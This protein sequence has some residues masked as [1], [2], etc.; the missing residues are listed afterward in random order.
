MLDSPWRRSK[1]KKVATVFP[2]PGSALLARRRTARNAFVSETSSFPD[3]PMR[4][5][6]SSARGAQ[7]N[8]TSSSRP[9]PPGRRHQGWR[10]VAFPAMAV[11]LVL[12]LLVSV[13]LILRVLDIGRPSDLND[14]LSGFSEVHNLFELDPDR[15]VYQT[16]V[17]RRIFFG[18]QE[19]PVEKSAETLRAFCLGGSTVRGRPYETDT[20]F[21]AWLQVE[22]AAREPTRA[23]EIVNCGGL[24]YASYRLVPLLQE[25]LQYSPDAII[26]ATGHNEFLEDRTYRDVKQRSAVRAWVEDRLYQSRLVSL[27]RGLVSTDEAVPKAAPDET[28]P[29]DGEVQARLDESTGYATYHRDDE[30]Q[31]QVVRQFED[32]LE[33]LI[34]LCRDADV[35]IIFVRLGS[36]LRD[37]PP[38]K[39]EHGDEVT[40]EQQ[41]EFQRLFDAGGA[42]DRENPL[43]AL[44]YYYQAEQ[45]D[46]R[47]P[48]LLFRIA[49]ALDRLG[50][51]EVAEA[52]YIR[53]RDEDV[54]PLR[55]VSELAEVV[56][57]V[58]GKHDV[59]LVNA[60]SLLAATTPQRI[61]G[62]DLY[63]DHV[64]PTIAGHQHIAQ[65]LA[66]VLG[67]LG[68]ARRTA[69]D[70]RTRRTAYRTHFETLSA[71]FFANGGRRVG[72][73][74]NWARRYRLL[75]EIPP[76][77]VNGYLRA[78]HR[79][80][81]FARYAKAWMLYAEALQFRPE[82]SGRVLQTAVNLF[83]QGR[84]ADARRVLDFL[85]EW[86]DK[87]DSS[88]AG[89]SDEI[90]LGR[91]V[92]AVELEQFESLQQLRADLQPLL[93][94]ESRPDSIWF[95]AMPDVLSRAAE[96]LESPVSP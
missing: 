89:L 55:M 80:F 26:V 27:A 16:A 31:K 75:D 22:L 86:L 64:H 79:E 47:Y 19:F 43:Q 14:P 36:N 66:G 33:R 15:G 65:A 18:A 7:D 59:P 23:F 17:S 74:E 2:Q 58:A 76:V 92:L 69:I 28:E 50:Q 41:R 73:L 56:S 83:Q 54:C 9:T 82:A 34:A 77:D 85:S 8:R 67:D 5:E 30:W 84:P 25:V 38:F 70:D 71:A 6:A 35:P 40:A 91:A 90:L 37:C 53:A 49:R 45:I 42:V 21:A 10:R 95:Q 78:A 39:S 48:L 3:N 12:L 88:P 68:L 81:N 96:F 60:E 46:P 61:P 94:G 63:L 11:L 13:E 52:Y 51:T 87:S 57:S 62:Y 44:E 1:V 72:W 24:S 32:S 4:P 93:T 29:L 20:A